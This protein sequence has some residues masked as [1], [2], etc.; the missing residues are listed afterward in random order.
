[1]ALLWL[2][3]RRSNAAAARFYAAC[4]FNVRGEFRAYYD[5]PREDAIIMARE[6]PAIE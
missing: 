3:V 1:V 5:D 2:R 4:G 6:V